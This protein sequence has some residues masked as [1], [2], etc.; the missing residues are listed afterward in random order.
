MKKVLLTTALVLIFVVAVA[1]YKLTTE[2]YIL[3][4][5]FGVQSIYDFDAS[6]AANPFTVFYIKSGSDF[7]HAEGDFRASG[8][9]L[10]LGGE[11]VTTAEW[12]FNPQKYL[13]IVQQA[14]GEITEA[15]LWISEP[16][17]T[18]QVNGTFIQ[19]QVNGKALQDFFLDFFTGNFTWNLPTTWNIPGSNFAYPTHFVVIPIPLSL[20]AQ[21]FENGTK[22]PISFRITLPKE[23]YWSID[24]AI[25]KLYNN[26]DT[27][28]SPW[29]TQHVAELIIVYAGII[30]LASFAIIF[31]YRNRL[32]R[33]R[34]S[35]IGKQIIEKARTNSFILSIFVLGILLRFVLTLPK[36]SEW[37]IG[38]YRYIGTLTFSYGLDTRTFNSIYGSI[39]QAVLLVSY[40]LY[41]FLST[42]GFSSHLQD[43]V[44][45]MPLIAS[46]ALIA[47]L[48]FRIG[49]RVATKKTAVALAVGWLF[50]PFSIWMSSVWGINHVVPTMFGILSLE[51]L[52]YRKIKSSA[53]ALSAAAFSGIY[54]LVGLF[55][56][57]CFLIVLYKSEG[58][59]KA[60]EFVNSFLLSSAIFVIPWP[61]TLAIFSN[62]LQGPGRVG[63]PA[64]S[65]SYLTIPA[66]IWI[67]WSVFLLALSSAL[68]LIY[69]LKKS[70]VKP[71]Q[72]IIENILICFLLFFLSYALV[73]PT[74][75]LWSLPWL[76]LL[77]ALTRKISFA[78]VLSFVTIPI[79]WTSFWG[80]ISWI[81]GQTDEVFR[82]FFG[83]S[84]SLLCMLILIKTASPKPLETPRKELSVRASSR[85]QRIKTVAQRFAVISC[86]F[87]VFSPWIQLS[88]WLG[89]WN[90]VLK[91]VLFVL[92]IGSLLFV[93]ASDLVGLVRDSSV[94]TSYKRSSVQKVLL[95]VSV[96]IWAYNLAVALNWVFP[97]FSGASQILVRSPDDSYFA[98]TLVL[99]LPTI[100]YDLWKFSQDKK[101]G[102]LTW[103]VVLQIG[104]TLTRHYVT[105]ASSGSFMLAIDLFVLSSSWI[106]ILL[107]TFCQSRL[108]AVGLTRS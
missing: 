108:E 97:V 26:V 22:T 54:P 21:S 12:V 95:I 11:N 63:F 38:V 83:L 13:T 7:S 27:L 31:T 17:P 4:P 24:Y 68:F 39:W 33:L 47:F 101:S 48:L 20:L 102:I 78:H 25:L 34:L 99:L 77:Y 46:D 67:Y 65:Y 23:V 87:I 81:S 98:L 88:E 10:Q 55:F 93:V 73:F 76:L 9:T 49:N 86:A 44:I 15:S 60:L 56:L 6:D 29:W 103:V 104:F 28:K 16:N 79:L 61:F 51:R 1:A 90:A 3:D 91:P 43:V 71:D 5:R 66:S 50:N 105:Y 32:R 106:L 94:F 70:H 14:G 18:S 37:D 85:T 107:A 53:V 52:A 40:P 96:L 2:P 74:Y 100:I 84:F 92:S 80:P 58:R 75:V 8:D 89:L 72:G 82:D 36:L 35:G 59:N 30:I 45:K 69:L 41:L 62:T 64:L 19:I 42:F 57:P